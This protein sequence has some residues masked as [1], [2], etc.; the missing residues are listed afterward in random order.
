MGVMPVLLMAEMKIGFIDSNRIIQEYGDVAA[1]SSE[2]EKQ[3]RSLEAEFTRMQQELDS[4]KADF[5]KQK[6]FMPVE[7]RA[8]REKEN[9]DLEQQ[10]QEFQMTNFGPGGEIYKIQSRLLDPVMKKIDEAI[11]LVGAERG[12]DYIL[13]ANSGVIVYALTSHDLTDEVLKELQAAASPEDN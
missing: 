8:E 5:D 4:L 9:L 10:I 2:I 12:Y 7:R 3:Q 1:V 6:L 11:Q 13:D